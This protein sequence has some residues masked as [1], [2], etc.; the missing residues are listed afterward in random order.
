MKQS[1]IDLLKSYSTS[2]SH[3]PVSNIDILSGLCPVQKLAAD[4]VKIGL[5]T[6]KL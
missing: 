4:G 6:G 5:G 3:C 1:E 2:V